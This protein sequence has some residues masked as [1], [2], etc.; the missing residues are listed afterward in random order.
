MLQFICSVTG[1]KYPVNI[2]RWRSNAGHLLDLEFEAKFDL[3]KIK[4]R[5]PNL[6]RYLEA[7]PI[8]NENSIVSFEEGFTPLLP[9][10]FDGKQAYIKQ[11]Q[12]FSTG[13]YKDRGATV[14]MS[15]VKELGIKKVIQDS[16]GNAGCAIAAYAA[17]ANVD[18][19]IYL[20]AD[21]AEAKIAQMR[22]YGAEIERV[23]GS[24]EDTAAAAFKAADSTFYAS[25]CYNPFFYQGT[26]T[27]AYEVCEQLGWTAPDAVV[28]PAGNGTLLIGCYIGFNDLLKAGI[29]NKLPK[30]IAIQAE[31]CPPL[32]Q[33]F[34]KSLNTYNEV[35]TEHTLA[36]GIAIA[37]PVR[38]NQLLKMV[39]ETK[40]KFYSVTEDEIENA[41]LYCGKMGYYIEPTSA[42]TIAGLRKYLAEQPT[43]LVVSLFTGHGLKSTDKILKIL[44]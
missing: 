6:W 8:T 14:L 31:A 35:P 3:E 20:P 32:S 15:F 21:T 18:C 19:R 27:F 2:P 36:E 37:T 4:D 40:G 9:I 28:V 29:I 44:K 1:K 30:I 25:H 12:L 41:L 7:L 11:E 17:K 22:M 10:D 42:A 13:S 26:K 34:D 5:K 16:S 33:A 24:R 39:R 43:E 38:G 23:P